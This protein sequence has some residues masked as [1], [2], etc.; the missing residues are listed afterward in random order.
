MYNS[1][2]VLTAP[3]YNSL[4]KS[5]R[6]KF[7]KDEVAGSPYS[8]CVERAVLVTEYFKRKEN[9][10]LPIILRKAEALAH[11]LTH[12]TC[13]IYPQELI[14]GST[15]SKRVAGPLYPELHG[16]PI[17]EDLLTFTTRKLNPLQITGK[18]KMKLVKDVAPY[19]LNKFLAYKA[20]SGKDLLN[21]VTDQLHPKFFL[22]NET[23]GIGHFIPDYEMLIHVGLEG[24]I[25][26]AE[27]HKKLFS[28]DSE[29]HHFYQAVQ[30]ICEGVIRMAQNYSA[31]V[32][33]LA[34]EEN[35]YARKTE[36]LEISENLE[37]VPAK[38]ARNFYEALQSIWMLHTALTLEGL[39]NG[40][41]FGRMDQYLLPF[42]QKDIEAGNLTKQRA[43][44]LL[45][46]LMIKSAEIIPVF[47]KSIIASHGGFLSGQAVT[48][49]G[50]DK[51]GNDVTNDL[52]YIFLDLMDEVRM[53]QPN[54]HARIHVGSPVAYIDKIM[55]HLAKGVN[56]PA[57]YNDEVIIRSLKRCGF[58]N[59]DAMEYSTL[60]C[61]ELNAAG[62]T[63]GS[64]DAAL[65]NVPL[66]LE[67]AL[68]RGRLFGSSS[69]SG[70]P[71]NDPETFTSMEQ[72]MLAFKEQLNFQIDRLQKM[73][74]PIE[75]GNKNY[76]PTPL[77]SSM[78]QGCMEKG[79]DVTAGGAVYN[80]SGVQGVGIT[81]VG[82]SLNALNELVFV[83]KKYPM[84]KVTNALKHNFKGGE[85][86][87]LEFLN[88]PKFGN[89]NKPA[90]WFSKWVA[91]CFYDSFEGK[92]NTRGGRFV[93]GFYS[94]TT[95]YSF[96][97]CT[98]A[99]A[100]GR[101]KGMP[102]TSGIAPTNGADKKGPTALF[103]SVASIDFERAHNG[104]NV[105]AKFDTATLKGEHGKDMLKALL[106]TYFKKGG[107]Q[108]QLNVLDAEMLKHAKEHPEEY[109]WLIVRVSGYS[110]YFNDLSPAM[111]DEII[112]RSTLSC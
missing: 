86:M 4:S 8:I 90:D 97:L 25:E 75:L 11:V 29:R 47:S 24:V 46:C 9:K 72:V 31:E 77:T 76:H 82:D 71:T 81:D 105:N 104:V 50:T 28:P 3:K 66:C 107:M 16:L 22:I 40:I 83:Q 53:R 10:S 21:F 7:L 45:G 43:K 36:L 20:F 80:F 94:T 39:D 2:E 62:K 14:V 112:Q 63:F 48:I 57:M 109:P 73:L 70:F 95:H 79:K 54:Y 61:V 99:M 102:F 85:K 26:Q 37:R 41:S 103:N 55:Q 38:G 5:A 87:R 52:S 42:Y 30:I 60:G 74:A 92:Y 17:M 110:A 18:E 59:E 64:T 56:S 88:V 23:G 89:D 106:L 15:T 32:I 96:G 111:K 27:M 1:P 100:N 84:A 12:K 98:G 19:W 34:E 51:N 13:R 67:M 91:D 44:E 49:G 78:I 65:V 108:V 35:D 69:L 101:L 93:A 68:N 6:L 58:S 33:R